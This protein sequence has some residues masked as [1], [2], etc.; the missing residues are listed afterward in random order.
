MFNYLR[1]KLGISD[2][3]SQISN[4]PVLNERYLRILTPL[5]ALLA[6][7]DEPEGDDSLVMHHMRCMGYFGGWKVREAYLE[8]LKHGKSA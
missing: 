4:I 3:Y 7:L 6:R 5:E 2:I 8:G 1:K